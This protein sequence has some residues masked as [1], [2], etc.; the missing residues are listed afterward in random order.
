[1]AASIEWATSVLHAVVI[2]QSEVS[3]LPFEIS[4]IRFRQLG[5]FVAQRNRDRTPVA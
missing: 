4:C 2:E 5:D 1:L 3:A